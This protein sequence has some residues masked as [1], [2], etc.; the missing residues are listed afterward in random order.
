MRRVH[1]EEQKMRQR[2]EQCKRAVLQQIEEARRKKLADAERQREVPDIAGT[3]GYP[4]IFEPSAEQIRSVA[5]N[6]CKNQQAALDKQVLAFPHNW[7][8]T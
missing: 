5:V 8:V 2:R 3:C 1:E 7:S 4:P 6:S